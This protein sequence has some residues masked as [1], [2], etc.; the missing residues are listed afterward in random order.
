MSTPPGWETVSDEVVEYA[1]TVTL[2]ALDWTEAGGRDVAPASERLAAYYDPQ[3]NYA[4]STYLGVAPNDP[5]VFTAADLFAVTLLRVDVDARSSRRLTALGPIHTR[6]A[7]LLGELPVDVHLAEADVNTLRAMATL[8]NEVKRTLSPPER[9]TTSDRW[10][11]AAKL[12]ARKRP[13]LFP[14]R[15]RVIR[16]VFRSPRVQELR[17]GLPGLSAA[18]ARP[19]RASSPVHPGGQGQRRAP[20]VAH[21]HLPIADP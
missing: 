11:T 13:H 2:E 12:C 20:G 1:R 5:H 7:V 8:H 4:G 3:G 14:V 21:R 19:T 6:L 16:E 15:D 10:V 9:K 18:H 17:G